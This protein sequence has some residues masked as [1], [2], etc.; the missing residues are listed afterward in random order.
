M[1]FIKE[2]PKWLYFQVCFPKTLIPFPSVFSSKLESQYLSLFDPKNHN[3]E[4][5]LEYKDPTSSKL[6]KINLLSMKMSETFP[7]TEELSFKP[8]EYLITR[9]AYSTCQMLG[10]SIV[11]CRNKEGK[12]LAVNEKDD[13][14]WYLPG[15]KVNPPESFHEAA[16]REAKEEANIDIILKG[17]LKHEYNFVE[18]RF[19]R[20]K[21]V[22]YA[23]P[24]D[25]K[26]LLKNK[27]DKESLE[28]R[29]VS[30]QELKELA[31]KPPYLRATELLDW[32]NYLEKEGEIYPLNSFQENNSLFM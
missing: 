18:G 23:E 11:I 8:A 30:L 31:K 25:E 12:F 28:A 21:V 20:Y 32:G 22:F 17:V 3:Y 26:Q 5:T 16:I 4:K 15:G 1:F 7:Q 24:K 10:I 6:F 9:K 13:R 29:W 19:L 2:T 27:P 14:G